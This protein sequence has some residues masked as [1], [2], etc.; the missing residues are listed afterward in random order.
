MED[1]GAFTAIVDM[2][3][4]KGFLADDGDYLPHETYGIGI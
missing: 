4:K 3:G 2:N 1:G